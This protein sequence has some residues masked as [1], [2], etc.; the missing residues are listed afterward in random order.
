MFKIRASFSDTVEIAA[1]AAKVRDFLLDM[2]NFVEL[3]PGIESIHTDNSG[4]VNWKIRAEI[5]VVGHLT[6]RFSVFKTEDSEELVE[7]SPA[8]GEAG[9]LL[10]FFAEFSEDSAGITNV[11]ISQTVEL[12]RPS[13]RDL[14]PLASLAGESVISREMT[15]RVSDMIRKFVSKAKEKLER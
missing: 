1:P 7:W 9:N 12:R 3:M 6:E 15:K 4:K 10:R 14:H 13:A 5:P 2:R 8:P 11:R